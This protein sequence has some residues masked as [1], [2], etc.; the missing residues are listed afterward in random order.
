HD[1]AAGTSGRSSKIIH[2]GL[3]YLK[4]FDF[5]LT[6]ES[7]HER[8]LHV[9]LNRRLVQPWP[10]LIPVYEEIGESPA[11]L[12][13]GM[14]L[15][16]LMSGFR[17]YRRHRFLSR[18][19]TLLMAPALAVQGLTGGILYYDAVVSDHRWTLETLKDG[20]RHGGLALNHA[21]VTGLS[22]TNDKVCGATWQDQLSGGTYE[23]RAEAVVNAT[24]IW[25]DRIRKLDQKDASNLV[26]L[27]KGTHLVFAEDDVPLTVSTVFFSSFD[28]RPLFMVKRDRCFLFG[29][30]DEWDDGEPDAPAPG[31]GEIDYLLKS[32]GQYMP[33]SQLDRKKIRSGYSGFRA[34]PAKDDAGTGPSSVTREDLVEVSPSG[35]VTVIGG[36][37]TTA[38]LMAYRVLKQ[39]ARTVGERRVHSQC[40][41][42]KLSIGGTNEEVAE[43]YA[44]WVRQCPE[45]RG[46]FLAMY[47]R[48]GLD[49]HDICA[50]V[51]KAFLSG[52][53]DQMGEMTMAE[54][55]YICRNEMPCTLEDLVERRAAFLHWDSTKRLE[56]LQCVKTTISKELDIDED[57][58]R[59][60]YRDYQDYLKRFHTV[61]QQ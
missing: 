41:T 53:H 25:A 40:Q 57:E 14:W 5:R 56:Q 30:T 27:S 38:R 21:R 6:W 11:L 18:E 3:R 28:K 29:T 8:N 23:I 49:A 4:N 33:G 58:Y 10:F 51:T 61:P 48:Y 13:S 20:I 12:R 26:K 55:E 59:Q 39:V 15:Y 34:L 22:K 47:Q 16:E 24:G 52:G 19:E 35:L 32:I 54:L 50:Q 45:L 44:Y 2:G 60:G 31:E 37:L 43:G 9:R 36:K 17:N 42:D 1:F 46:Y 7:C